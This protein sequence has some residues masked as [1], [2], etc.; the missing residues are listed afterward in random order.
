M[1]PGRRRRDR[2]R[3]GRGR[4]GPGRRRRGCSR[5]A[6]PA[7]A[8]ADA[9]P[10]R[11]CPAAAGRP[12]RPRAAARTPAARA[13]SRRA[14]G[15]HPPS[16]RI[17]K[18]RVFAILLGLGALAVVSTVFGMMMAVT[19]DL[20]RLEEPAARNSVLVDREG[21]R[22]GLLT[23]S[24]RRIFVRAA[25]I[26]PVMKQAIIAVEDRR[27]YTNDGIDYRGIG[28]ALYQD[29]IQQRVVQG[30]STIT[31]QFV[32]NA[33]AAQ[34]DRTVFQKLREAALAFQIT[35]K[36]S[37]E[38][39]LRNYLNT[40]YFGN[41]AYGIE[42]AAKTYFGSRHPGCGEPGQRR[43]AAQL[44]LEEAAL[45]AGIVASPSGY[46]PLLHPPAA[47]ERRDL[48]LDRMAQ[49]GFISEAQ[50]A[51][52]SAQSLPTRSDIQPPAED[53]AQPVLHVVDQAAGGRP[54]RRRPGG[55]A[56]RLR[57]RADGP[58]HAGHGAPGRGGARRGSRPALHRGAA[59]R[60]G[61]AGEP[62]RRGARHGR[63]GRLPHAVL[64]PRH[65]GAAP[66]G[67]GVQAVRARAG[68]EG[69]RLGELRV[70]VAQARLLHQ[71]QGERRL[72]RLLRGEQLRGR[73][74]R[75]HHAGARHDV[76][77]QRGLREPRDPARHEEDRHDGPRGSGS[78][79]PSRATWR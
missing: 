77:G 2:R 23:G 12:P 45:L 50:R 65:A 47:A 64:Q 37:K 20:P 70:G 22:L 36:W 62:V 4:L 53:T 60:A 9:P 76:L 74:R 59:R 31:Q 33:L 25:D 54:A 51:E 5:P 63:R 34:D 30:G 55:R 32:K 43:C 6:R 8:R 40:I 66:A 68:A 13:A 24:D 75:P 41:G 38:R 16:V 10:A 7:P 48:V 28:R 71:A 1:G 14:A 27:F 67:L 39:I 49:Q 15:A 17:R 61:G 69:R 42:S 29:V 18:L 73:L 57:G 26:A 52:A 58:H 46:D 56:A 11:A 21:R 79:R 78:A 19:S 3:G 44:D 72:P 35:R